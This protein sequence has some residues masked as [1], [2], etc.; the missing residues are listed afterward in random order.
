MLICAAYGIHD[1]RYEKNYFF[2]APYEFHIFPNILC[3]SFRKNVKFIRCDKEVILLIS[4]IV[5]AICGAYQLIR[6]FSPF[7]DKSGL[8]LNAQRRKH[9][10]DIS[11]EEQGASKAPSPPFSELLECFEIIFT[12]R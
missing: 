4:N 9:F 1:T 10:C 12:D 7:S 5:N 11:A 8:L 6:G 3:Y 2:I